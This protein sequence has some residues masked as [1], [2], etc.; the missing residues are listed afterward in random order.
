[1]RAVLESVVPSADVAVRYREQGWWRD[2][3]FSDDLRTAALERPDDPILLT[4][5]HQEQ[6]LSSLSFGEFDAR[7]DAVAAALRELG[8]RRGDVVAHQLPAMWETAVLMVACLRAGAVLAPVPLLFGP[9]E[10]ERVLAATGAVVCVVPD[11]F[12]GVAYGRQ[13]AEPAGRL[14]LLRHRIVIG[15]AAD[16]GAV[17]LRASFGGER[18]A[19]APAEPLGADEVCVLLL[20][21]G[22]TGETQ[23][24]ARSANTLGVALT[25]WEPRPR[26]GELFGTTSGMGHSTG[27]RQVV[28]TLA[29]GVPTLFSDCR[30]PECWLRLI[31][32]VGVTRLLWAAPRMLRSLI[33]EQRRRPRDLSSLKTVHSTAGPLYPEVLA[34]V[35]ATLCPVVLNSWGMTETGNLLST[36]PADP[37]H[38]AAQSLGRP[39]GSAQL[40][41][42]PVGGGAFRM[43]LRGPAVGLATIGR[44]SGTVTWSLESDEGWLD[45]G[46]VVAPDGADGLRFVGRTAERIGDAWQIPVADVERALLA[47]S[48]IEDAV[49]VPWADGEGREV[50]C[51]AVISAAPLE[52]SELREHVARFGFH[53]SCLPVRIERVTEF[54]RTDMGKVRRKVLLDQLRDRDR[55]ITESASAES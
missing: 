54:P 17:S 50:P 49:L 21:S 2:A 36:D 28:R 11:E 12:D 4:W 10:V 13:L 1:M 32:E 24:V 55:H 27:F 39:H 31:E 52:L 14:P 7:A 35:R 53:E 25:D 16:S 9:F 42:D 6:R 51:A 5:R 23:F 33:E 8:V 48:V 15:D 45:T 26:T 38:W 37:G 19:P 29:Q 18:P 47:H 41:L 34:E 30:H 40:R 3:T 22:T 43:H 20:T 46:D 44:D